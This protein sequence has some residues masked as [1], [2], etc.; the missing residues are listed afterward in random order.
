M[1]TKNLISLFK[2][3][4]GY[5]TKGQLPNRAL[6]DKLRKL[7]DEGKVERVK[8]GI[9]FMQEATDNPEQIDISLVVPGGV[10]CL[11][12]CWAH[13]ELTVQVPQAY[14]IAIEKSRK[15]TLP[16]YPPIQLHYWQKEYHEMGITQMKITGYLVN[17]YDI[18]KSVCDAVKFRNKIGMETM[19]EIL[20]NYLKRKDRNLARLMDYAKKMR[21]ANILKTY[22]EVQ[23]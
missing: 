15:V 7:I 18:H 3:H 11:Y 12:S 13:Y 14:H 10:L 4:N 8:N 6:Y 17:M 9:Y 22:L 1:K 5:L 19:S 23:L 20:K 21:V 2:D 16:D